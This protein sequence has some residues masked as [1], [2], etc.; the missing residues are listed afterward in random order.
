MEEIKLPME[1][2]KRSHFNEIM[3]TIEDTDME[4]FYGVFLAGVNFMK[5]Y[6]TTDYL[7]VYNQL[8][9]DIDMKLINDILNG[10]VE[11]DSYDE[12]YGVG[13]EITDVILPKNDN[14]SNKEI[15]VEFDI[16]GN[17]GP[18]YK[19]SYIKIDNRGRVFS[20]ICESPWEGG[21][22]DSE[23]EEIIMELISKSKYK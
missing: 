16:Q 15:E 21:G 11:H 3:E 10:E 22:I 18:T 5:E 1:D 20:S 13:I 12:L 4:D 7:K 9:F 23:I 6:N 19:G 17:R 2:E 8:G 14:S